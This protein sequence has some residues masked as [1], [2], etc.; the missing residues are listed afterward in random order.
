VSCDAPEHREHLNQRP[1]PG[2]QRRAHVAERRAEQV[3]RERV[4]DAV[5]RFVGDGL[6][7]I[8]ATGEHADAGVGPEALD[9]LLHERA[10]ADA[11]LALHEH[12][13]GSAAAH[14]DERGLELAAL[15]RPAD[16]RDG[17]RRRGRARRTAVGR[18]RS[19][20]SDDLSCR[21]TQPGLAA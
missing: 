18:A 9:E 15:R 6:S 19:E 1:R 17:A 16:E 2:G 21:R 14:V 10:L 7:L 13:D 5:E 3:P 11:R 8:A 20:H 12:R 4:D